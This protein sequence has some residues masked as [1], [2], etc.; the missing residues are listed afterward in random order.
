MARFFYTQVNYTPQSKNWQ[1]RQG[2]RS[3]TSD[4]HNW[5]SEI[6]EEMNKGDWEFV[7]A[8]WEERV[9]EW[10]LLFKKGRA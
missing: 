7:S 2:G 9:M 4:P 1:E 6:C 10:H 5:L 3:G 8:I